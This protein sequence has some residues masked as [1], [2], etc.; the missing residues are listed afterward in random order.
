MPRPPRDLIL[1]PD[2]PNHLVLRGNNRRRL[3]SYPREYEIFLW[4]LTA[5][6]NET[7]C[8]IHAL[9]LMANHV[10][11]L[12]TPPSVEIASKFVAFFAQR[13]AQTRNASRDATG[14][15]FEQRF[16]SKPIADIAHLRSATMYIEA[17]PLRAGVATTDRYRWSTYALH[18]RVS[19][20]TISHALWTP[21]D[22][23]LG[24]GDSMC[25]RSESYREQL[26]DYVT[27]DDPAEEERWAHLRYLD[28]V[29]RRRLLRPDGSRAAETGVC[30]LPEMRPMKT[31]G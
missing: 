14:K 11:L 9:C 10:H 21:S 23:Y 15:L 20:S 12:V 24:L 27:R 2:Q 3:F 29:Y 5:A 22:W 7:K 30:T 6:R 1:A 8:L 18:A 26:A 16:Y 19:S 25:E 17:N 4:Y 28:L 31:R 13:Y